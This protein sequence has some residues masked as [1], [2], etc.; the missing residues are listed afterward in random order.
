MKF[1]QGVLVSFITAVL[2]NL[3]WA[4]FIFHKSYFILP[5][6]FLTVFGFFILIVYITSPSRMIK[7]E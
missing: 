1:K 3:Y 5:T 4:S 6:I 2:T 7:G